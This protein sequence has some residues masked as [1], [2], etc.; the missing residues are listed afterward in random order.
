[1]RKKFGLLFFIIFLI[2]ILA[3][4]IVKYINDRVAP[5]VMDYSIGQMK[6]V[7]STIINRSIRDETLPQDEIDKM[8]IVS[9]SKEE[10][11]I[12][13]TLDSVIVNKIT[14]RISD[15][16]ED[17]LRLVEENRFNEIKKKFNIGEEYF[18]VPSGIIFN[19]TIFS[20]FGPK[21]P[22]RLKII[23]NV[24]SGIVTNVKEY[25]I[26]NS[27]ITVS[28]EIKVE[29]MVI[30]PFSTEFVNITNYVPLAIK[31]IQGK[32]PNIYGGRL[33]N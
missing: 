12:S 22:I 27:L 23:G 29:L 28:V 11:V 21:I 2:I 13:V 5:I 4:I 18:L 15:A 3:L 20:S 7:S 6:R 10:E 9:K 1:M 19:N 32:V 31:I 8:F 26:N 25:G 30:L 33:L 14:N 17:N 16:C 24:T